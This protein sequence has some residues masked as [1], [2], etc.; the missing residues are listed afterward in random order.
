MQNTSSA[1]TRIALTGGG[2]AG[3]VMP[4]LALL[5]EFRNA[6]WD[7]FYIG[8]AGIERDLMAKANVRFHT[9]AVGKL[10]RYMSWQNVMD[11]FRVLKGLLQ[12]LIIL[13]R[14]KPQLVF[15]KG[16]FVSVPVAVAAFLLRIPVV[17]H[18]SDFT[19]GLANRIIARFAQLIMYCFPETEKYLKRYHALF[20]GLPVR[21]ELLSGSR[22]EGFKLC[23][24]SATGNLPVILVMGGSQGAQN[25]NTALE[26]I[27]PQL[28]QK[29]RVVHLTGK[30]KSLSYQNSRYKSFEFLNEELKHIFAI[31][32]FVVSRS[33]ANSI[34]EFLALQKPMLLIP[35][36]HGSRGDQV[37]NARS[38][39][40]KGWAT[41]LL[42]KDL[43]PE[44]FMTAIGQL[45]TNADQMKAEQAKS[46]MHGIEGRIMDALRATIAG[47]FTK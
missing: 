1:K 46:P 41:T 15:S 33:G 24:F 2:T 21:R 32:D 43:T 44:S 8:S 35:L 5:P 30:G 29:F 45:Q 31:A 10:R 19:P 16:G 9:I 28:V 36:V 37:D 25:I 23:G 27:L 13:R 40:T 11:I 14:E 20:T 6:N 26:S 39:S 3:H 18:E 47:G 22:E 38:F 7:V 17:S 4:H 34:F 42:E 12:A